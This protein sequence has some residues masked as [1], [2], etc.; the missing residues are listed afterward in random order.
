MVESTVTLC[1]MICNCSMNNL[2]IDFRAKVKKTGSLNNLKSS[3]E[4]KG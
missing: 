4:L 2:F 1:A 3:S